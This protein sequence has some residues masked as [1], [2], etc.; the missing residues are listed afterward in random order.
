MVVVFHPFA[1]TRMSGGLWQ[2]QRV[3]PLTNSILPKFVTKRGF[4]I[5]VFSS[6]TKTKGLHMKGKGQRVIF[7][8]SWLY[9]R[10]RTEFF[11]YMISL[12]VPINPAKWVVLSPLYSWGNR[13]SDGSRSWLRIT[14]L[15][16]ELRL[17]PRPD[18]KNWLI[19]C[20]FAFHLPTPA[21]IASD[22]CRSRAVVDR[23]LAASFKAFLGGHPHSVR[24]EMSDCPQVP[25][26]APG[27]L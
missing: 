18:S 12:H 6:V 21:L 7:T 10:N 27:L 24:C 5:H 14:Q 1:Y 26:Q 11:A 8:E 13:G 2:T 15:V 19:F 25:S 9:T 16:T 20:Y 4:A 17:V 23:P 3:L 22:L